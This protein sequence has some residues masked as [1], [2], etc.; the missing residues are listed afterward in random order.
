MKGPRRKGKG[1]GRKKS[2]W[3]RKGPEREGADHVGALYSYCMLYEWT[4]DM[5]NIDEFY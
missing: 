1:Q 2:V 4:S 3:G 5:N